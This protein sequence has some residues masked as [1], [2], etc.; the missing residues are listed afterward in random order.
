MINGNILCRLLAVHRPVP[1]VSQHHSARKL[2]LMPA[3]LNHLCGGVIS[4]I[5]GYFILKIPPRKKCQLL[6]R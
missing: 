6:R 3:F 5:Y 2:S 4:L 1:H